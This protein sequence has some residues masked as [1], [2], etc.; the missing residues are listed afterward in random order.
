MPRRLLGA[1]LIGLMA[2]GS[3]LLRVA[4]LLRVGV[5]V[6]RLSLAC[7]GLAALEGKASS[8]RAPRDGEG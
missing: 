4:V 8:V 3:V 2:V 7:K 1:L 6:G 5:P